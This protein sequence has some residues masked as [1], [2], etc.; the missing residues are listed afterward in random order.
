M[1]RCALASLLVWCGVV[2][3][4]AFAQSEEAPPLPSLEEIGEAFGIDRDDIAALR[5]KKRSTHD[6]RT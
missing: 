4:V 1:I 2:P 6:Y 3:G 5:G